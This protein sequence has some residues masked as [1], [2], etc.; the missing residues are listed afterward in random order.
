MT[1]RWVDNWLTAG[2]RGQQINLHPDAGHKGVQQKSVMERVPLHIFIRQPNGMKNRLLSSVQMAGNWQEDHS[3]IAR[4]CLKGQANSTPKIQHRRR[5]APG[6]R[7]NLC[8][9]TGWGLTS[10]G[11]ALWKMTLGS[12]QTGDSKQRPSISWAAQTGTQPVHQGKGLS[13]S[14]LHL[15]AHS[16]NTVPSFSPTQEKH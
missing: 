7:T 8:T 1:T 16:W 14:T 9:N 10:W 3:L 4:S 11:T 5:P 12:W 15:L 6:R 13:L 2:L